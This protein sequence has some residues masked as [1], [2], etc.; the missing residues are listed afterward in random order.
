MT[1]VGVAF[2]QRSAPLT[3]L[4]KVS[5]NADD[6]PYLLDHLV[7]SEHITEAV[8]VSTCMRTEIY[9]EALRFHAAVDHVL[10]AM[11]KTTGVAQ[12]QLVTAA[13]ERFDSVAVDHLFRVTAGL[14]SPVLG[15][16]EILGQVGRA[17]EA[18]Q[19]SGSARTSM[20]ALFRHALSTGRRVRDETAIAKGTTS[21]GRAAVDM[22]RDTL[23]AL[24]DRRVL[25]LG[26][27][28]MGEAMA[29]AVGMAKEGGEVAVCNRTPEKAGALADRIDGRAVPYDE[30]M[31]ELVQ[32]DLVLTSSAAPEVIIDLTQMEAVMAQRNGNPLVIVDMGVPR[33][34]A[35]E[36]GDVAGVTVLDL[37]DLQN[38]TEAGR[39]DRQN[40]IAS[41]EALIAAEV[42]AYFHEVEVRSLSPLFQEIYAQAE[43]IR[44][45]EMTKLDSRV[46]LDVAEREIVD[47][48]TSALVAKLLHAP[49]SRMKTTA[50]T[51]E[52]ELFTSALR[53][54]LD[55]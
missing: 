12:H 27:G 15:E 10:D 39:R 2:D 22:A 7:E 23:G 11:A 18:A 30:F 35:L 28:E 32:T 17:L 5:I 14:E 46:K 9:C 38:F 43:R 33:N 21:I 34:V 31:E 53:L 40:E 25:M 48:M 41:V 26:A 52:G 19:K 42:D 6:L 44:A 36:A 16:F 1:L 49:V 24:G 29:S 3:F 54:M 20:Q 8:V 13:I 47:A 55:K 50:G 45:G 37:V 4:E 51:S